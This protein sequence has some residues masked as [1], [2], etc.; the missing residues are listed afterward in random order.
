MIITSVDA[1][2]DCTLAI[3]SENGVKPN[4]LMIKNGEAVKG[5]MFI[6]RIPLK[7]VPIDD[8]K[9]CSEFLY[10]MYENKVSLIYT[11]TFGVKQFN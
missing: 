7:D 5:Q 10:K 2:Y 6:N 9:K 1:I 4:I 11:H 8:E 3:K